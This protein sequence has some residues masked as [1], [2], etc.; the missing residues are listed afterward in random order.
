MNSESIIKFKSLFEEQRRNLLYTQGVIDESF[1]LQKD[2]MLDEADL[3]STE[4]EQSMRMRLR[5]RE[6]LFLKKIDEA[7]DRIKEGTF[8]ECEACSEEIEL[9]RLEARPT[10]TMCVT[11]TDEDERRDHVHVAGRNH[12]SVGVKLRLA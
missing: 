1:Q 11:G 2:D 8:G 9:R 7:L 10:A 5:N 12:Q 4:L 6:A 3:T